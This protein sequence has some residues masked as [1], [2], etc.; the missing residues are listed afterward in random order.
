MSVPSRLATVRGLALPG[1]AQ[2][3]R[4]VR[5]LVIGYGSPLRGDDAL[6]MRVA[7]RLAARELPGT[8]VRALVQLTPELAADIAEARLAIFVDARADAGDGAGVQI[9]TIEPAATGAAGP[10]FAHVVEPEV[11]LALARALFGRC[12]PAFLITAPAPECGLAEAL[13]PAAQA[14]ADQAAR[15]I[16]GLVA[17]S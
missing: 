12:P 2:A 5:A 15:T 17:W 3:A 4:Q 13:S 7:E 1:A 16:E 8:D 10:L 11:L 6:G 9:R 14:F